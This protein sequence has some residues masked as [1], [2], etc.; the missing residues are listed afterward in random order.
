MI[1][2]DNPKVYICLDRF[3][4]LALQIWELIISRNRGSSYRFVLNQLPFA[5]NEIFVDAATSWGIGGF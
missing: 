2:H 4:I 3:S 1:D 5:A